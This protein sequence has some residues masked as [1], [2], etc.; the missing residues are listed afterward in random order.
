MEAVVCILDAEK[1]IWYWK[2][3]SDFRHWLAGL[4]QSG[5][6]GVTGADDTDWWFVCLSLLAGSACVHASKR[7]VCLWLAWWCVVRLLASNQC[8]AINIYIV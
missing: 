4:T 6:A 2:Y 5:V 8:I 7:L 1:G 3:D